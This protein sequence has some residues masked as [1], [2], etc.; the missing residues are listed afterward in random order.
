MAYL[1]YSGLQRFKNDLIDDTLTTA[2]KAADAKAVGDA[3]STIASEL[4]DIDDL[5]GTGVIE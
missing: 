2:G 5:I 4:S 3:L 1:D